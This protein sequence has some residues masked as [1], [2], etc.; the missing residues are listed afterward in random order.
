MSS[1]DAYTRVTIPLAEILE[2]EPSLKYIKIQIIE[3]G[4]VLLDEIVLE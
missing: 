2:S 1:H 3:S 4:S